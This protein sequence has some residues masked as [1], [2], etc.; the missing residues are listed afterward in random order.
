MPERGRKRESVAAPEVKIPEG[1]WVLYRDQFEIPSEWRYPPNSGRGEPPALTADKE[2]GG[3]VLR[4]AE[5]TGNFDYRVGAARK[6]QIAARRSAVVKF[7]HREEG[8][9]PQ[10]VVQLSVAPPGRGATDF[11]V[12]RRPSPVWK[13]EEVALEAFRAPGAV[14]P[15]EP[16]EI[17]EIRFFAGVPDERGSC[18]IDDVVICEEEEPGFLV[19][20]EGSWKKG[21]GVSLSGKEMVLSG[22][23]EVRLARDRFIDFKVSFLIK[24]L[25]GRESADWWA[26]VSFDKGGTGHLNGPRVVLRGDG[27]VHVLRGG[28]KLAVLGPGTVN[29]KEARLEFILRG[30]HMTI[31]TPTG[32]YRQVRLGSF[33]ERGLEFRSAPGVEA[34]VSRVQV[35]DLDPFDRYAAEPDRAIAEA[36]RGKDP[37]AM[38]AVGERFLRGLRKPHEAL[39]ALDTCLA[40]RLS[41]A[42]C[43]RAWY[44]K[45]CAL[46]ELRRK[47]E[48]VDLLYDVVD[49]PAADKEARSDAR[50]F[51]E[52][53]LPPP[54]RPIDAELHPASH[55]PRED[56]IVDFTGPNSVTRGK[57]RTDIFGWEKCAASVRGSRRTVSIRIELRGNRRFKAGPGC[58]F[59]AAVWTRNLRWLRVEISD[60][61]GEEKLS[62]CVPDP[63]SSW[64]ILRFDVGKLSGKPLTAA[65]IEFIGERIPGLDAEVRVARVWASE[66]L[67]EDPAIRPMAELMAE[68]WPLLRVHEYGLAGD[69]IRRMEGKDPR[70]RKYPKVRKHLERVRLA[71]ELASNLYNGARINCAGKARGRILT[72]GG[73]TGKVTEANISGLTIAGGLGTRKIEIS[74]MKVREIVGLFELD[75][76]DRK[77]GDGE[78]AKAA[79]ARTAFLA[80]ERER[81]L[82]QREVARAGK[83]KLDLNE[84]LL[85]LGRLP[86]GR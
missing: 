33:E 53:I 32:Q 64:K 85:L 63:A 36:R 5:L 80:C 20:D 57:V 77:M 78:K 43:A 35:K 82:A 37:K 3:R 25:S 44:E 12:R 76:L 24:R 45:A 54:P 55:K 83:W 46:V 59:D 22:G 61:E 13:T 79:A 66:A 58:W 84:F 18:Y 69:K 52:K 42:L 1:A 7:R 15:D 29:P 49:A 16:V 39:V 60:A 50:R 10:F 75:K 40:M 41:D 67:P 62:G 74:E 11:R 56:L 17:G 34:A 38:C 4:L 51:L 65:R 86:G 68:L 26:G 19:L 28:S 21:A 72:L 6:L 8:K 47:K 81:D 71:V 30:D 9:V 70:V 48:A 2:V 73:I 23:A 14:L 27:G 31:R